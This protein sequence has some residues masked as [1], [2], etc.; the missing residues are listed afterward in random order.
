MERLRC[1]ALSDLTI[2]DLTRVLSGPFATAWLSDMG[3]CVIKVENPMEGDATRVS[4]PIVS[5]ESAYFATVNRNKK[6]ISINLKTAKGKELFLSLARHADVV[7]ENFRPGVM[8]KLGIGFEELSRVNPRIVLA[9]ISGYGSY[10]PYA[11]RPGYDVVSQGMGGIMSLTGFP[12]DPPTKCGPSIGDVTAGMNLVIGVLAA[13]HYARNTGKGQKVEVSLV[14]SVLALCTQD[15][16]EYGLTKKIPERLG[17]N[18][19]L[20]CPYGTYSASNGY[21]QIGVG[22]ERHFELL[23]TEVLGMPELLR[24]PRFQGQLERV[25]N[26]RVL[27]EIMEKWANNR[28]VQEVV[29]KLNEVGI[30][31]SPVYNFADIEADENFT[32][33]REMI[34]HM[35]H[36]VIGDLPYINMPVRFSQT[37][38][39]EPTP[40]GNIGQYNEE[41]FSQYL[42]LTK[43]ELEELHHEKVI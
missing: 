31:S 14:D 17:N 5:G 25:H 20:W 21:Y 36:P 6:T 15:Y 32:K 41:I 43:E 2:L 26:R 13:V 1:G 16:I 29:D 35:D 8:D 42:E 10:G 34:K 4:A 9:S 38:L 24:D 22:T 27:D 37:S 3:A 40:A 33:H 39:V 23:C 12:E 7:T 30:P 28:T 18:Y 11:S 19:S